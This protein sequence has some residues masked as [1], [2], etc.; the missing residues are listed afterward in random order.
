MFSTST[1]PA[2]CATKTRGLR[3]DMFCSYPKKKCVKR[4]HG[5]PPGP[6]LKVKLLVG[7]ISVKECTGGTSILREEITHSEWSVSS[8]WL[9]VPYHPSN[10][11]Y[12]YHIIWIQCLQCPHQKIRECSIKL[13]F[14][15]SIT[16]VSVTQLH[17]MDDTRAA[18]PVWVLSGFFT[19]GI[20]F[21]GTRPKVLIYETKAQS[22]I[23][24][25]DCLTVCLGADMRW[26]KK[27]PWSLPR[28]GR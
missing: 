22:T 8:S 11:S 4:I 2:R 1:V 7:Y 12:V 5:N 27:H 28:R 17:L 25:F 14:Q 13:L 19:F 21:F 6:L 20:W 16:P 15:I 18:A 23:C 26:W 24:C 3:C 10:V 9:Y